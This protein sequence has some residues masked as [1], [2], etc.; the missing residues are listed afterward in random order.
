LQAFIVSGNGDKYA[1]QPT[2][3][4]NGANFCPMRLLQQVVF[5]TLVPHQTLIERMAPASQLTPPGNG[6]SPGL[7]KPTQALR[8]TKQL[9]VLNA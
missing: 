5:L 8:F 6:R 9:A 4:L 3:S 1:G 2:N 7:G